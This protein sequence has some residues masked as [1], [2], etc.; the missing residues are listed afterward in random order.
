MAEWDEIKATLYRIEAGQKE[1]GRKLDYALEQ[2]TRLEEQRKA[3]RERM[4]DAAKDRGRI[5]GRVALVEGR[6]QTIESAVDRH[7]GMTQA[8][9]MKRTAIDASVG[10]GGLAGLAA[11]IWQLMEMYQHGPPQ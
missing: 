5:E 1:M 3:D 4:T 2:V 8:D 11:L 7:T 9:K 10:T 6:L